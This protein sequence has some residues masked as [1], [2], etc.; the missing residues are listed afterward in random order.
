MIGRVED[1]KLVLVNMDAGGELDTGGGAITVA[2]VSGPVTTR[3][4]AGAQSLQQVFGSVDAQALDADLT[5]DSIRGDRLIA[6]VH[7]G[8]IDTRRVRSR[9]VELRSTRGDITFEGD[10]AIGWSW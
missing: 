9:A 10:A 6:V 5:L 8:R 3:S 2:N 4:L 7:D 1:G